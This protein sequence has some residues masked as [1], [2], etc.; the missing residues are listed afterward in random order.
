MNFVEVS[1]NSTLYNDVIKLNRQPENEQLLDKY[2]F[3]NALAL[4][5]K[6]GLNNIKQF[7]KIFNLFLFIRNLGS[8]T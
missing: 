3:S 4:S 1:T 5:V 8:F 2:T 6:L 7:L